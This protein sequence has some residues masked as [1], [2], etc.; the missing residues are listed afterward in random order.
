MMCFADEEAETE[1]LGKVIGRTWD[2]ALG[3]L[4]L[5]Q[6]EDLG[7]MKLAPRT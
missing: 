3:S 4:E 7:A 2:R 1:Q 5:N 6:G